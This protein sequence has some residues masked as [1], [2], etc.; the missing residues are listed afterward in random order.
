[1]KGWTDRDQCIN[2]CWGLL[3]DE[4][5]QKLV[6]YVC[7]PIYYSPHAF[8]SSGSQSTLRTS[9]SLSFLEGHVDSAVC[10]SIM[11]LVRV[12]GFQLG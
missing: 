2:V 1:M 5:N 9:V 7:V 8:P 12:E 6:C 4:G 10:A 3:K 11:L